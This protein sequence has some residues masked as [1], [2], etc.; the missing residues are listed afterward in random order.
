[1]NTN[2]ATSSSSSN[3]STTTSSPEL[4]QQLSYQSSHPTLSIETITQQSPSKRDNINEEQEVNL[5]IYACELIQQTG[6]LL[7]LPQ[8][9]M[10]RAQVLLHRFYMK[11]SLKEFC[12]RYAAVASLFLSSKL[13]D[14]VKELQTVIEAFDYLMVQVRKENDYTSVI[15]SSNSD[16]SLNQITSIPILQ[17]RNEIIR[18]ERHICTDLGFVLHNIEFPHTYILFYMHVLEGSDE[19]VQCAWNYCNDALRCRILSL[20]VKPHI[21]ACGAIFVAANQLKIQLPDNPGWWLV[22]EATYDDLLMVEKY[23][24][25][26]YKRPKAKYEHVVSPNTSAL[27]SAQLSSQKQQPSTQSYRPEQRQEQRPSSRHSDR[28]S[29]GDNRSYRSSS[30]SSDRYS[31]SSSSD[32]HRKRN[33]SDYYNSNYR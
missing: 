12:V 10:T 14:H 21:L 4:T 2:D 25:E 16:S 8:V 6:Q 23:L 31:R 28:H 18:V 26:L 19:L 3:E 17:V 1:M 5:Q 11:R 13:S 22:F 9:V 30:S 33:Y 7:K 20:H 15:E 24:A 32:R 27:Y 29:D